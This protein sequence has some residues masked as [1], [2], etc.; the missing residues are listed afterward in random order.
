MIL[1]T[2]KRGDIILGKLTLVGI[3]PV[4]TFSSFEELRRF[5][6][7]VLGYCEFYCPEVPDVFLEAFSGGENEQR[8]ANSPN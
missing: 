4:I 2:N 5:A 8:E 3:V 1:S 6:M 7:G